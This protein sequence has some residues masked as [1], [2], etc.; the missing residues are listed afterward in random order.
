MRILIT[1]ATG[2]VGM[3]LMPMLEDKCPGAKILLLCRNTTKAQ[4]LFPYSN[5]TICQSDD[6]DAVRKFQPEIVLHLASLST[7]RNDAEII[8]E[9]IHSNIMYG[10]RLL[11]A[12]KE[13]TELRLLVNTGSFAEYRYGSECINDA[14]L[15]A[16]TKSAFRS[17]VEYYSQLCSYKYVNVIPY[18]IYGGKPTVKRLMD[19]ILESMDAQTPVDMTLGEQVLDFTHVDDLCD[20]YIHLIS[21]QDK[22]GQ[23]KNGESFHVGTGTGISIRHLA[24]LLEQVYGKSCN[25]N[26][27]GRSYRDRDTMYA[28]APIAKNMALL[29]W[30]AKISLKEGIEKMKNSTNG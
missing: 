10:V 22:L 1:G 23:I 17:F 20:F 2:F 12:L 3:N 6:W 30:K 14:Y 27:G 29:N 24:T 5:C 21:H 25:I 4:V 15:Y 13:D 11:D 18:T 19:Y 26:W 9:L 28:V 16:A 7:S 8:P